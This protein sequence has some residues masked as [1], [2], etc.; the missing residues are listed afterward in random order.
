VTR[1]FDVHA[2]VTEYQPTFGGRAATC[3]NASGRGFTIG[4]G[5]YRPF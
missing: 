2:G 3:T 5:R 1:W 4:N